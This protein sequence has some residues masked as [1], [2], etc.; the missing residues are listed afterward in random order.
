MKSLA[1]HL[2]AKVS[3]AAPA[4]VG[5]V[6][7]GP[8]ALTAYLKRNK[9]TPNAFAHKCGLDQSG[10]SRILRG[11]SGAR[12]SADWAVRIENATDGEVKVRMWVTEPKERT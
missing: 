2:F 3:R 11:K 10:L 7:P 4:R 1:T 6:P 5:A 9:L 12:I 8:K